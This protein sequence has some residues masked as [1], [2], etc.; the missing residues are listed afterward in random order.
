ML[1]RFRD[2]K[3]IMQI[4]GSNVLFGWRRSNA[5]YYFS[6][7]GPIWGWASW[8]RAWEYYD[9]NMKHWPE[10][11]ANRI[12]HDFCDSENEMS[13]RVKL[14][15]D[16][17]DGKIN[18]W[19][20]QWVFAKLLN[21]GLCIVPNVNLITNIGFTGDS[22]HSFENSALSDMTMSEL[23]FPLIHPE[24]IIRDT[25]SDKVFFNKYIRTVSRLDRLKS[26]VQTIADRTR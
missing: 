23:L 10:V 19:D 8:R 16:V 11:K 15:D 25:I 14:F 13:V 9:V 3:R 26:I 17:Y 4:C 2:D 20:Y 6:K 5:S 7:Y 21:S 12:H 1:E 24:F 22:T 18:T